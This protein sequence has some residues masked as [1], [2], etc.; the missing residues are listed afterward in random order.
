MGEGEAM[1]SC[2]FLS[3]AGQICELGIKGV[4]ASFIWGMDSVK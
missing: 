3:G 2:F 1:A 4:G